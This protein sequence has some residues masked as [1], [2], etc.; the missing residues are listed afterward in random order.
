MAEEVFLFGAG[1]AIDMRDFEEAGKWNKI[2]LFA[3]D[4]EP[5]IASRIHCRT[6]SRYAENARILF[7][8]L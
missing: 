2:L 7:H 4:A 8:G 6:G 5:A 1:S 3:L